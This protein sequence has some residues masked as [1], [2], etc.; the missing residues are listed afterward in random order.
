MQKENWEENQKLEERKNIVQNIKLVITKY[1]PKKYT[2]KLHTQ[3]LIF[4][5]FLD[6]QIFSKF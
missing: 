4:Q 3:K 6:N 2:L 1:V 5:Y